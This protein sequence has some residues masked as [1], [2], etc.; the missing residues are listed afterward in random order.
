V[1]Y[2]VA[3]V[4]SAGAITTSTLQKPVIVFVYGQQGLFGGINIAGQKITER[5]AS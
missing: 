4:G 3:D 2:A 5:T 1:D